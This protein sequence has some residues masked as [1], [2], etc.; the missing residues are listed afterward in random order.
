MPRSNA[1][2][3]LVLVVWKGNPHAS[4][5]IL[6]M[7]RMAHHSLSE[8]MFAARMPS[9]SHSPPNCPSPITGQKLPAA[10]STFCTCLK[11]RRI[12]SSK[13][14]KVCQPNKYGDQQRSKDKTPS[15]KQVR[16]GKGER[17]HPTRAPKNGGCPSRC[18]LNQPY[19]STPG[20]ND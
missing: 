9:R 16:S 2:I 17:L 8:V 3:H 7:C 1:V 10:A 15:A 11:Q 14:D 19:K 13:S 4:P 18:C 5:K 6:N 20:A 12:L